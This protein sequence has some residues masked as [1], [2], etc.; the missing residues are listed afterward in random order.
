MH[1]FRMAIETRLLRH[2][3]ISRLDLDR[4][5]V[6]FE[7]KGQRMKESIVGLRHPFADRVVRKVT[8]VADRNVL[9]TRLLPRIEVVLHHVTVGARPRIVAQVAGSL[10]VPKGERPQTA[11]QAQ[12]YGNENGN[13]A[14]RSY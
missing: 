5:V 7:R 4:F 6:I 3:A 1:E 10:A 9:M 8:V 11:E 14:G 13:E 2:S 12:Q